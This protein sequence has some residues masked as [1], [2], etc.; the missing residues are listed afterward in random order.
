MAEDTLL[1]ARREVAWDV[2]QKV[3]DELE[4]AGVRSEP[5]DSRVLNALRTR[6]ET[7]FV[8]RRGLLGPLLDAHERELAEV[9]KYRDMIEECR[10][11]GR[12]S[13]R[14]SDALDA[15]RGAKIHVLTGLR[16]AICNGDGSWVWTPDPSDDVA[17]KTRPYSNV[18]H[19]YQRA[20]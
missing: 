4:D 18:F 1:G 11:A 14:A 5:L 2:A 10:E 8:E 7:M 20:S 3:L 6:I 9:T 19:L 15:W 17:V 13:R 12:R 16:G